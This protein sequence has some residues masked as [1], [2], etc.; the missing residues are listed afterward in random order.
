[1][2]KGNNGIIRI[3]YFVIL[4]LFCGC[5]ANRPR[6]GY[7]PTPVGTPFPDPDKLGNHSSGVGVFMEAAGIVYTCKAGH[8][9]LDH[10]RGTADTTKYLADK[11]SETLMQNRTNFT[12][13]LTGEWSSHI[14]TFTFPANWRQIQDKEKIIKEISLEAA[15]YLAMNAMTWHEILTWFGTRFLGFEPEFNSAFSWEDVYSNLMG[16]KLGVLAMQGDVNGFDKAMTILIYKTL[17][18]MDVRPRSVA[19]AA[20]KSVEGKWYTGSL[21][22][23]M[24]MRNFDIGLDGSITPLLIDNVPGCENCE[25]MTLAMPKL[26]TLKDYGFTMTHEIKPNVFEQ[27][28]IFRAA[29]SYKIFPEKHYPIL[30]DFM[31]REAQGKGYSCAE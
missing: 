12:F 8:I 15:P 7:L 27:D 31:K 2:L 21:M 23:D 10:V 4:I 22:P 3:L 28:K 19:I 9:D 6:W 20:S 17:K 29:G 5:G 16:A 24:K 11:I 30:L 25:P 14:V 26:R 1:M 18:E 13:N